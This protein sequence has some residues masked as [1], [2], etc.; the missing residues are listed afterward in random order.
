[1]LYPVGS[2]FQHFDGSFATHIPKAGDPIFSTGGKIMAIWRPGHTENA[3][4]M[5][6][7]NL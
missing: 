3:A 2:T 1:M 6:L 4:V 7:N 5:G